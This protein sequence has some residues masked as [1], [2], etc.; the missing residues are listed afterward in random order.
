MLKGAGGKAF[1]AGG[2][3]RALAAAKLDGPAR[4]AAAIEYFRA[5]DSLV[6]KIANYSKPHVAI[7]DGIVMVR[8]A[9]RAT[10]QHAALTRARLRA[11]GRWRGAVDQRRAA[12]GD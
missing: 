9:A 10:P 1:C 6:Y 11:S 3:V 12:R 5:E 8:R 2:D 4:V 7:M